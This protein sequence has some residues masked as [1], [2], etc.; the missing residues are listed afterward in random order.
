MRPRF[1]RSSLFVL[2]LGILIGVVAV[3]LWDLRG[4]SG[5][6]ASALATFRAALEIT[7]DRYVEKDKTDPKQLVY[8]AI[9]GMVQ[10]LGDTGHSRFLTPEQRHQEQQS[11]SGSFVGI[12]VEVAERD[13]HVV[14]VAAFPD[15]PAARAG[16]RA[17]DRIIKVD[18]EDVSNLGLSDLGARLRGPAGS[19][20]RLAVLHPDNTVMEVTV[21]RE[22][23]HTPFVTWAPI[24]GTSLWHIHISQFGEGTAKELDKALAAAQQAGA[25]G[26]L[27]DLRDDPGGL[28]DEAVGVASRFIEDGT[29]LIE[30]DRDGHRTPLKVK[31]GVDA[32]SLPVT[33]LINGGT[34]SASEVVAAALLYYKRATA[35]GTQ[36]FG[37]GTVL[38]TFGLPDGSA[39]LLGVQEWLTP[40][41]EPLWKHG[42]APTET[43]SLPENTQP[44]IPLVPS[45][46]PEQPCGS[47][48]AQLRAAAAGMGLSCSTG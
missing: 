10:G 2:A 45:S 28:L 18:G 46:S 14:V 8:N 19:Q 29:V 42:V 17:G 15:S 36:T 30:Q 44:V 7:H 26:I 38:Q 11:L 37:T 22:E 1:S 3:R 27:L 23:I 21:Q 32:T 25:T 6:E 9:S 47:A 34:A 13:G 40:G 16:L 41:G 20:V 43:V 39:L 24:T 48:D 35:V 4:P 12:G 33:L 5:A 31:S